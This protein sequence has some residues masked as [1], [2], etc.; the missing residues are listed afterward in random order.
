[1]Q[2]GV[3]QRPLGADV[4][5]PGRGEDLVEVGG[6]Q[7]AGHHRQHG[8]GRG[9]GL[10]AAAAAAAAQR[11]LLV[12]GEVADLAG[13]AAGAVEELVVDDDARARRRRRS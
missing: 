2:P 13:G 7:L 4:P 9:V 12:E 10:Q 3:L 1:M 6:R 11:A 5:G 8:L